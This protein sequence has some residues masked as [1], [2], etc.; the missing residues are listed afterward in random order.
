MCPLDLIGTI[1]DIYFIR[2]VSFL[3]TFYYVFPK[4]HEMPISFV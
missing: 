4:L 3:S 1:Y 2:D